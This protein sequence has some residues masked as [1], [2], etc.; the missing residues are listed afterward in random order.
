VIEVT[1]EMVE[2]FAEAWGPAAVHGGQATGWRAG[3][4]AALAIVERDQA[5]PPLA[6]P[7][8]WASVQAAMEKLTAAPPPPPRELHCGVAVWDQLLELKPDDTGPLGL[9]AALGGAPLYGVPVHVD[10]GMRQGRWELREGDRVVQAGD[11]T[12]DHP[13]LVIYVPGVGWVATNLPDQDRM[14][15]ETSPSGGAP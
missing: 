3:L 14:T 7:V 11:I 1:D 10:L 5:G 6:E 12:P 9:G 8:T 2:A 13:G 4:A 15:N